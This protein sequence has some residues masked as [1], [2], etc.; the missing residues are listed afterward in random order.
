[1]HKKIIVIFLISTSL[2]GGN[3]S[4]LLEKKI[5]EVTPNTFLPVWIFWNKPPN[6]SYIFNIEIRG[7]RI[8]T[9]SFL[10]GA[11][12]CYIP[13]NQIQRLKTLKNVKFLD[14]VR[15]GKTEE[16]DVTKFKEM[17]FQNLNY[18]LS[19]A[20]LE[21]LNI[22]AVHN[23][24]FLGSGI[25][26]AIFDTG[27]D[28]THIAINHIWQ[29][30][31][32]KAK[33]D[34]NSGDRIET[35][36]G[37]LPL[38]YLG[39]KYI[40]SYSTTKFGDTLCVIYSIAPE[41]SLAGN[42]IK[43]RW[44][45]FYSYGIVVDGG[46]NW[47]IIINKVAPSDSFVIQ[48]DAIMYQDSL[49]VVWQKMVIGNKFDVFFGKGRVGENI[50]FSLNLSN[51]ASSSLSPKILMTSDKMFVVWADTLNGIH[52]ISS[53]DMGTTFSED[54]LI[55]EKSGSFSGLSTISV[56]DTLYIMTSFND[57]LFYIKSYDEESWQW[58]FVNEG[59]LPSMIYHDGKI[60]V[61]FMEDNSIYYL[62][63]NDSPGD[64]ILLADSVYPT[65]A[66]IFEHNGN[67]LLF[68]TNTNGELIRGEITTSGLINKEIIAGIFSD[69]PT[70]VEGI[71]FWRRRGD[72]NVFIDDYVPHVWFSDKRYHGTKMLAVIAGF[73][74]GN[75]IG[76]APGADFILA[77]T[78]RPQTRGGVGFEN[79]VEEDFWVEA[80]E[81]AISKGAKI[82]SSS[83]GYID[84]YE[85][86]DLDGFTPVT[87]R[88][89]SL[90]LQKG[91]IVVTAMGNEPWNRL[92][93]PNPLEGDT[94]LLAPADAKDI[95]A[96]GAYS[97]DS[98]GN[99]LPRGS[100]GPTY[101]GRIKPEVIAPSEYVVTAIDTFFYGDTVPEYIGLGSGTSYGTALVAGVIATVWEAHPSWDAS[102]MR[103]V[104]LSTSKSVEIPDYPG[105]PIP[106][107]ITG[108]GLPDAYEALFY[109]EPEIIP[110]PGDILLEP[111]PNPFK[112]DEHDFLN[113]VFNLSNRTFV[114]LRIYT[115]SGEKIF[116]V[117]LDQNEVGIG[118]REYKWDGKTSSGKKIS[119]GLYIISMRTGFGTSITKF[120]VVR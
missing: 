97:L 91:T 19:E 103:E 64:F 45:L 92:F 117:T 83:L 15:R 10:I 100:Y 104:L 35:S 29:R 37:N 105:S 28:S 18:G 89:A 102:K 50:E 79:Q 67:L 71:F 31:G 60:H 109:E 84:W 56:G 21:A 23:K 99:F 38:P 6:A 110:A 13:A 41:E 111:Y 32:I 46:I 93:F 98:L 44:G 88:A 24:G 2:I 8:R 63:L 3:T 5:S 7:G 120:A 33:H 57:S 90:A 49:Y 16:R 107:N 115:V 81:W 58:T 25:K 101:D 30:G 85:K 119:P 78:E 82:V 55:F 75:L 61:I 86:G 22:P 4:H 108:Y 77:K 116:E 51:D 36:F 54:T 53:T 27:F 14:L 48:P 34:F 68:Y 42:Y 47:S 113:I 87:S 26:I 52:V 9:N 118:R 43:N 17:Y 112:V 74:P 40:N 39:V 62:S 65:P 114:T 20:Q 66:K 96:V 80:L 11:S 95:V 106:N 1:M 76:P 59:T 69:L 70:G 73:Y 72:D 94:T 12:S